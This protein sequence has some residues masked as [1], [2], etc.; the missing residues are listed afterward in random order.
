MP[1]SRRTLRSLRWRCGLVADW[2]KL[3]FSKLSIGLRHCAERTPAP[4]VSHC[5]PPLPPPPHP[6]NASLLSFPLCAG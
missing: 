5:I 1:P 6:A 4:V 2:K 3:C